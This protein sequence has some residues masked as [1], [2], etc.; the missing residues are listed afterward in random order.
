VVCI[1]QVDSCGQDYFL[2]FFFLIVKEY[3]GKLIFIENYETKLITD[4]INHLKI[5]N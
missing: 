5:S 2:D 3:N 1:S 4:E